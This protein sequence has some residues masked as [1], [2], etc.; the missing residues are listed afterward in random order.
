MKNRKQTAENVNKLKN[1][2]PSQIH[3]G[4]SNMGSKM[5]NSGATGHYIYIVQMNH[6]V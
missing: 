1:T 5:H 4:F 3:F 2:N 6:P